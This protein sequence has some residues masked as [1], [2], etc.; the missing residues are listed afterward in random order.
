MEAIQS[1]H[2]KLWKRSRSS[3]TVDQTQDIIDALQAARDSIAQDP[4]STQITLAKLQTPVKS[5]FDNINSGLKEVY[6]GLNKYSRTLD[7]LFKDKSLPSSEI[8]ALSPYPT[9]LTRAIYLHF[10]R[11][12]LFDVASTFSKEVSA[13]FPEPQPQSAPNGATPDTADGEDAK[14]RERPLGVDR[15]LPEEME[16][17]FEAMY[18]ILHAMKEDRDLSPAIA[19]AR[20]HSETLE[21]RGSNLEFELCR[22]EFADIFQGHDEDDTEEGLQA[23]QFHAIN[24]ARK[25]FQAFHGRYLSE[26]QQLMGALV[27]GPNLEESP[28]RNL[29]H[30][31]TAWDEVANSFTREFCSLLELSADSPLYIAATAGAIALPTLVKLQN[32]MQQKRTEWTTANELPVSFSKPFPRCII[33]NFD[34]PKYHCHHLTNSTP[35][36]FALFPRNRQL[37]RILR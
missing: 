23:R 30:N 16:K 37:M 27:Y 22:L 10:L 21:A 12:G 25:Q 32:I 13:K 29:L 20:T 17:Q 2:A 24:Y 4:L 18:Y 15:M 36:S 35:S 26:I 9:L 31:S 7:K 14:E 3:K 19:W 28:Y 11:E 33:A 34:R 8:D 1:E 5:S 6:G